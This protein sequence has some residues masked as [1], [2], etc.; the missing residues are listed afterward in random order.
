MNENRMIQNIVLV[1][2]TNELKTHMV[3]YAQ[4]K[5]LGIKLKISLILAPRCL[6]T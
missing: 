1:L 3:I 6:N 2:N 5:L 4:Q